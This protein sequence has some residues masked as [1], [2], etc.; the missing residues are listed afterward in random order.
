MKTGAI[1]EY[2]DVAQLVLYAFWI[3]F[4]GL[5][6]YLRREDKREGYPLESDRSKFI[7]VVGFPPMPEPKK[8]VLPHGGGVRY[9]PA[10]PVAQRPIAAEPTGRW[11]GAPLNPTGNPMVDGVGPGS[12]GTRPE[13]PDLTQHGE[14]RI[15]PMRVATEFSVEARDPDPRGKP[16]YGADNRKAGEVTDI[17]VDR[18]EP[19]IRYLEVDTGAK[20]VLLPITF[21]RISP[22]GK[23]I[24]VVSIRAHQ[25]ADVPAT[26]SPDQVTLQEEDKICAYYGSGHLYAYKSRSEPLL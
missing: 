16:V 21:V 4:I 1:T 23:R 9:A 6:Y 26:S 11:P 12:Y 19:Q 5:V 15:V 10:S 8:F 14:P 7:K 20:T 18:G 2:I 25:F 3:F 13:V 17:W 22:N 24:N